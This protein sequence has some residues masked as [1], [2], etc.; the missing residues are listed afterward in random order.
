MI[1][2]DSFVKDVRIENKNHYFIFI[3]YFI[4]FIKKAYEQIFITT[5][6]DS[7]TNVVSV[8]RNVYQDKMEKLDGLQVKS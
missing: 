5:L 8:R 1:F 4:F 3:H 6:I 7:E 2:D